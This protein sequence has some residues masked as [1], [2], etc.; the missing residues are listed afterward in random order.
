MEEQQSKTCI[1]CHKS[2]PIVEFTFPK[3]KNPIGIRCRECQTEKCKIDY[4]KRREEQLAYRKEYYA[5]NKEAILE[6]TKTEEYKKDRNAKKK[7]R[8]QTDIQFRIC[9]SMKVRIH[10]VLK[11]YKTTSSNYLLGCTKGH[12]VNW[13]TYQHY[14][15]IN[16]DNYAQHWHIDH[17]IPLDF[18]DMTSKP[19]Q[20]ICF[21]W[22]NLRPLEKGTNMSKSYRI[23]KEDILG[24]I[25]V[26]E[27]FITENS[28]YQECYNNSIWPRI[29]LGYGENLTDDKDFTNLLKSI[30]SNQ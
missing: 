26:I 1:A 10:E 22:L 5:K 23:V 9:E 30:I 2:K 19:Q 3:R 27:K 7:I 6:K 16:W 14:N 12:I 18:F 29:K 21:N 25:E 17:V 8:R 28:E 20:L 13:L 4:Q 11:E 15:E 24:H